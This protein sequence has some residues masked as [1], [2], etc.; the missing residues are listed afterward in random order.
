MGIRHGPVLEVMRR[1]PRHLFVDEALADR[2]YDDFPLPIG[3]GQ[4]I[5]QPYIVARMTE[6]L[7]TTTP[8]DTVLEIGTGSG[9][10]TA[11]LAALVRRVYSIERVAG[12]RDLAERRLRAL[13]RRNVRLRHGDGA[14]GWREYAPFDG[15][16]L[17]AAPSV[18]P[19]RLLEQLAI[20][21]CMV[22]PVGPPDDQRLLR[23]QKTPAGL[24][25]EILEP[26]RFVP[27][28]QGTC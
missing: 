8:C 2:A 16:L 14:V 22:L 18:P 3:W 7:L 17:T 27:M 19:R 12:L 13:G 9:F 6:A 20:G 28:L 10:Q 23:L 26:V 25:P 15:I 21:G 11:V 1:L 5:S 4:S 24:V